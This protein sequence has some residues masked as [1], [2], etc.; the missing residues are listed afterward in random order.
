M[1]GWNI[2]HARVVDS[3]VGME[4]VQERS[5]R[6]AGKGKGPQYGDLPDYSDELFALDIVDSIGSSEW[7]KTRN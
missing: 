6:V 5:N 4:M 7:T 3:E 1:N 2:F